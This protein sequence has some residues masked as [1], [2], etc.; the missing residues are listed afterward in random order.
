MY[1]SNLLPVIELSIQPLL[2][3]RNEHVKTAGKLVCASKL[4]GRQQ[5]RWDRIELPHWEYYR[6]CGLRV[7]QRPSL[8]SILCQQTFKHGHKFHPPL[9]A[10][11]N[12][13]TRSPPRVPDILENRISMRFGCEGAGQ[14][15][16]KYQQ[17]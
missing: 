9:I 8:M 14:K 16:K 17:I 4:F 6:Y 2:G 11:F 3:L 5:A 10:Q 15:L 7:E 12:I 13:E 1:L